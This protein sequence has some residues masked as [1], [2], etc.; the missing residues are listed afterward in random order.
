MFS[1]TLFV[2]A[3]VYDLLYF[4]WKIHNNDALFYF[5]KMLI[6]IGFIIRIIGQVT[7]RKQFSFFVKIRKDHELITT[8]IYKYVRHPLY[9]AAFLALLGA[10][11][12][13]NSWLGFAVVILLVVP[14]IF[15][16]IKVE[17]KAL[18]QKFGKD[19]LDY[20]KRVKILIPWIY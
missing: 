8:G 6:V 4:G 1:I 13:F 12:V 20:K 9:S 14:T 15:Y 18:V 7:L 19:Y 2:T 5:G 17:E 16:R 3:S 11:L 10:V